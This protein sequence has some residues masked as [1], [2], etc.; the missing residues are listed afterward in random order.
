MSSH[1]Y[2]KHYSPESISNHN[3]SVVFGLSSAV[4][5]N[6]YDLKSFKKKRTTF[7]KA[8]TVSVITPVLRMPIG[9][10]DLGGPLVI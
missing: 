8:G 6:H 9:V 2:I 1:R 10:A 3:H 7:T 4:F 5:L